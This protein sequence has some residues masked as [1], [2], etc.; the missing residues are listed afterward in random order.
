MIVWGAIDEQ[1]YGAIWGRR[2]DSNG[3]V[4]DQN[5][6]PISYPT[7]ISGSLHQTPYASFNSQDDIFAVCWIQGTEIVSDYRVFERIFN[8]DLTAISD[9]SQVSLIDT[10]EWYDTWFPANCFLG[11]DS[12]F[13]T[14][15]AY[16][17]EQNGYDIFG[18]ITQIDITGIDIIETSLPE[19]YASVYP[20]PFNESTIIH[21]NLPELSHV[22]LDIYDILGRKVETLINHRQTSGAYQVIWNASDKA[23]GAYFYRFQTDEYSETKKMI[24]LK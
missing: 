19:F 20:N 1:H 9:T 2:F 8:S 21:Y 22:T 4:I 15:G 10:L 17:D 14:W 24:L 11:S 7:Y 18:T 23:S 3:D 5:D 16:V 12:I 6:R 13:T